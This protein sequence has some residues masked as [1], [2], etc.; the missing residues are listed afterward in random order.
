MKTYYNCV[1]G[2][3][4]HVCYLYYLYLTVYV[5]EN[6]LL[7]GGV[8]CVGWRWVQGTKWWDRSGMVIEMVKVCMVQGK[9]MNYFS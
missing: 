7:K 5:R 1:H 9:D 3:D 8:S 6:E 2:I 4:R